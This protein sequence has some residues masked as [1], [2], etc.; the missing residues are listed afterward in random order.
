MKQF[1]VQQHCSSKIKTFCEIVSI[2]I[3]FA[4]RQKCRE[5][6]NEEEVNLESAILALTFSSSLGLVT[7]YSWMLNQWQKQKS[8]YCLLLL[9]KRSNHRVTDK[10]NDSC[11]PR[12]L[13]FMA[14]AEWFRFSRGVERT[15]TLLSGLALAWE[16]VTVY[17]GNCNCIYTVWIFAP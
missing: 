5:G 9:V 15:W 2:W 10:A 16:K 8:I 14:V 4:Q 7:I 3:Y 17:L 1:S 12:I 6:C 11:C 13:M